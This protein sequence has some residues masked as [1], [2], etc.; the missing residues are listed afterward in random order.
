MSAGLPGSFAPQ[1]DAALKAIA[2]WRRDGGSQVFRLFGYAGTGKTTALKLLAEADPTPGLYVAYNKGAQLSA[3]AR[4]PA[5]VACRTVHSLA[6]RA[7][8]MADQQHRLER[9]LAGRDVA[10]LLAIPALDGLRSSFWGYC[11]IATVRSFTHDGTARGIGLEHLP[12]L[13]RGTDR[14]GPVLAWARQIWVLMCDPAGAVPLEHD[15]LRWLRAD[16]LDSLRWLPSDVPFLA[17]LRTVY[18]TDTVGNRR[19]LLGEVCNDRKLDSVSAATARGK[20][21]VPFRTR[22]LSLLAP[23]V[24]RGVLRGRVGRRRTSSLQRGHH[25]GGPA[26]VFCPSV[27]P[28]GPM[29]SAE[30]WS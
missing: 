19:S 26:E 6:Y 5:H 13:P 10:E 3:R 28:S 15:A 23:M 25:S 24:L 4:F 29:C 1:Q 17:E 18:A 22:K 2:A 16:D 7:M 12:P 30:S 11:V 14:A 27:E 9:R 20:R 21:P 8:H